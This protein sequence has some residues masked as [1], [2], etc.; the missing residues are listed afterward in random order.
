LQPGFDRRDAKFAQ[1]SQAVSG[2][3]RAPEDHRQPVIMARASS[4]ADIAATRNRD[5]ERRGSFVTVLIGCG[6]PMQERLERVFDKTDF[7][8]TASTSGVDRLA[9]NDALHRQANLLI[10]NGRQD[11]ETAIA[12]VRL[13]KQVRADSC[14][15]VLTETGLMSDLASL[16]QAGADLCFAEGANPEIFLKSVELMMGEVI[17][18]R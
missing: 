14:V 11:T 5:A 17:P 9:S 7:Q 16:F 10:V 3:G 18:T 8:V 13:I 15:A 6:G 2:D 1:D 12:Q 4:R